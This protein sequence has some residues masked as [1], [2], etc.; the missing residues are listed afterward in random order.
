MQCR[1]A[2][3]LAL[4]LATPAWSGEGGSIGPPLALHTGIKADPSAFVGI[5]IDFLVLDPLSLG[6]ATGSGRDDPITLVSPTAYGRLWFDFPGLHE[7]YKRIR[8]FLQAGAGFTDL[9]VDHPQLPGVT[10][11]D[12]DA[13]FRTSAGFG[14][15]FHLSHSFSF[16]TQVLFHATP[17]EAFGEGFYFSWEVASLRYRF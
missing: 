12:D 4:G 1:V 5:E 3:I 17:D 15:N 2:V 9:E 7:G 14:A 11:D 16:G 10:F 8:P 6:P 13:G